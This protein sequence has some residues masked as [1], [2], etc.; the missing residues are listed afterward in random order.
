M[1]NYLLFIIVGLLCLFG[2]KSFSQS[3]FHPEDYIQYV[4]NNQDMSAEEIQ[5]RYTPGTPYYST[6]ED[7]LKPG[8]FTFLDSI[9]LKY[10]LTDSEMDL[11]A[12][13]HFVVT[14]RLNF[15]CFGAALHD[16]YVKDLPVCVTTDAILQALHAS[17]DKILMNLE[18]GLLE[19]NLIRFLEGLSNSYSQL[20]NAYEANPDLHDALADVDIYVTLAKSLLE[21]DL[22]APQYASVDQV[23]A[24]WQAVQDER[25]VDMP[26]FSDRDRHLDFSQFTPRG[27]YAGEHWA[28]YGKIEL[29]NYFKAMMWLGRMDFLLTP[30]PANPWEEPWTREEIRRMNLGAVLL[31]QLMNMAGVKNLLDEND[32]IITFLVGESDNL[33]PNELSELITELNIT[34][35]NLLD[36]TTY[37]AFQAALVASAEYG[38]RILSSFFIMDPYSTEP[39]PLP[40]SYRLMGQRFII[41][42]YVLGNVVYDRIIYNG[43]KVWRPMPDPLDAM[44]VL[45]NDNALPLLSDELEIYKYASQLDALRYLVNAYDDDFWGLSLYNVWLQAIRCLN[46]VEDSSELPYFMNTVAWQQEKLNTQLASWTQLRHDNLLYAKQSYT[47]GTGCSF[48]HSFVEPYPAFYKQIADFAA[49]AEGYF[50]GLPSE[51]G[52]VSSIQRYFPRLK[53]TML[54]LEILAQKEV[55]NEAF[56]DEEKDFLQKMLFVDGGSG[57]PPFSGWYADLYYIPDDAAFGEYIVADVHTQPT[58]EGGAV[59][60][61]V[62]HVGVGDINLGVFLVESYSEAGVP[63]AFVGP[64]MSYYEKITDNFQ[65]L[66]DERWTEMVLAN[67]LP[68]RPDWVN[69]YLVDEK[70]QARL[71][72]R[73]LPGD[74]YTGS[75]TGNVPVPVAFSLEQNYPNPFNP[76]TTIRYVLPQHD[77]VTVTIYDILGRQIETLVSENQFAGPHSVNWVAQGLPSG[78]Y[79]CRVQAGK[80]NQ[81]IKMMLMQ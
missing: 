20:Q 35:D 54:K 6:R 71:K 40:V 52:M 49:K 7:L 2:Q 24:L 13:N 10:R 15:N 18:A 22:L 69:I 67:D 43:K 21:G 66:T 28:L 36:D 65:R 4:Q 23:N 58:D 5:L 60:G 61:R 30:P 8:Q 32:E 47:G 77:F 39:D 81:M 16:I 72:G 57:A 14:E 79:M 74:V 27:H 51:S 70:G 34:P 68:I 46:P 44:F 59:V 31:N 1:K 64:V 50:A 26:L 12:K 62:L 53:E 41:D 3:Q 33:T 42:S 17:Y 55:N 73:E 76:G 19:P 25:Q 45:G 29:E 78:L 63:M 80:F 11:L 75:G 48:P 56:T 37:D 38:Q 9:S